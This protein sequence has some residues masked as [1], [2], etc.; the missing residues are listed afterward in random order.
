MVRINKIPRHVHFLP[1]GDAGRL[2]RVDNFTAFLEH[3][4]VKL[5]EDNPGAL[6]YITPLFRLKAS[7]TC[8]DEDLTCKWKVG[9]VQVLMGAA[10]THS[11]DG[12]NRNRWE[13]P[14]LP[15]SD[16]TGTE[17]PWYGGNKG[18]KYG[19]GTVDIG[20]DDNFAIDVGWDLT[21]EDG[22]EDPSC[23]LTSVHRHQC[24]AVWLMAYDE[25]HDDFWIIRALRWEV[26]LEITVD[27]KNHHGPRATVT[28]F[29]LTW[30]PMVVDGVPSVEWLNAPTA[31]DS[32]V[33]RNS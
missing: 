20:M 16:S 4:D 17:F 28:N 7:V 26:R 33:F 29:G 23:K 24:F 5:N 9:F 31:N 13:F 22:Q 2:F 1:P 25:D 21:R 12:G 30:E 15:V 18:Y 32:Q 10:I 27:A 8:L 11:Y 14:T 3:G 6:Q 19:H